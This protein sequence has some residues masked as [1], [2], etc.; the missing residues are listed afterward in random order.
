MAKTTTYKRRSAA[1][2]TM[3][4]IMPPGRNERMS[5][6]IVKTEPI[7][8]TLAKAGSLIKK[9]ITASPATRPCEMIA[10]TF[11]PPNELAN[12]RPPAG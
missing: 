3:A 8:A 4:R 10:A 5:T 12:R 9:N 1:F 7:T 6:M 11:M 2:T